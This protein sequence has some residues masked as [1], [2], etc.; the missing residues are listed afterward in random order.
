MVMQRIAGGVERNLPDGSVVRGIGPVHVAGQTA[1][2]HGMEQTRIEFDPVLPF[3]ALDTDA[4]ERRFPCFVCGQE[5]PV[6][7]QIGGFGL[8]VQAGVLDRRIRQ[9]D[10]HADVPTRTSIETQVHAG[11]HARTAPLTGKNL[12][13]AEGAPRRRFGIHDGA[14]IH[15]HDGALLIDVHIDG[16]GHHPALDTAVLGEGHR[17]VARRTA[18]AHL[19][20]DV[21]DQVG[22]LRSGEGITVETDALGSRQFGFHAVVFQQY[23]VIA[24]PGHLVFL[25]EARTVTRLRIVEGTGNGLQRADGRGDHHAAHLKF[26]EIG[27]TFDRSMAGVVAHGLPAA[28]ISEVAVGGRRQFRHAERHRRGREE[29]PARMGRSDTGIDIVGQ[30][31]GRRA[32]GHAGRQGNQG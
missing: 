28:G 20:A 11:A 1:S 30:R 9:A 15:L 32:G 26:V 2:Q 31:F 13:A 23:G 17:S 16:F 25:V 10:L 8:H 22:L 14:E 24:R 7:I 12:L 19:R 27:E 21:E 6:E 29:E 4:S 18:F 5:R 3:A